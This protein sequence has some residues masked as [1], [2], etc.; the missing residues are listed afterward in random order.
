ML[1]TGNQ[2][3]VTIVVPGTT[4]GEPLLLHL[5]RFMLVQYEYFRIIFDGNWK[6]T[7][8]N[9]IVVEGVDRTTFRY[10]RVSLSLIL[11]LEK[12]S[13]SSTLELSI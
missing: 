9:R 12:L 4:P 1:A 2:S 5:H 8:E 11:S 13:T 6:E 7:S 3:D 10:V